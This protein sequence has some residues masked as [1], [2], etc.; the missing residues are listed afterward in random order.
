MGWGGSARQAFVSSVSPRIRVSG[1]LAIAG[2]W[3]SGRTSD[4]VLRLLSCIPGRGSECV[5]TY[6]SESMALGVVR[7]RWETP[8]TVA[9]PARIARCGPV[10][11]VSDAAVYGTEELGQS[12]ERA[13]CRPASLAPPELLAAAVRIWGKRCLERIEG[14][15]AFVAWDA[16]TRTL[17]AARDPFGTRTLFF[18]AID[19]SVFVSSTPH[20]LVEL[21]GVVPPFDPGGLLRSLVMQPGGSRATAWE[22]VRELPPGHLLE[23]SLEENPT[24]QLDG[25]AL[26]PRIRRFWFPAA[27]PGMGALASDAAPGALAHRLQRAVADRIPEVGAALAMSGGYD[28]TALAGAYFGGK[29]PPPSPLHI[30]SFR[31]HRDDPANEDEYVNA[32]ARAFGLPIHWVETDYLGLL[33][34]SPQ[35]IERRLFPEGHIHESQNRALARAARERG[36]RVL[37]NGN[38]GDNMIFGP[39]QVMGDLLRQGRWFAL[40]RFFRSRGYGRWGTFRDFA[41]RPAVPLPFLDAVERLRGRPINSRPFEQPLPPWITPPDELLGEMRRLDR[42]AYAEAVLANHGRVERRLRA[43]SASDPMFARVCASLFD[44]ARDEGVELRFPFYDGRIV[45][46]ALARPIEEM[47]RPGELKPLL[48]DSM[49]ERLPDQVIAPRLEGKWKTG[50][51]VEYSRKR[52]RTE[53]GGRLSAL[54]QPWILEELGL[55]SPRTYQSRLTANLAGDH[56]WEVHLITTLAVEEWLQRQVGRQAGG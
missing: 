53:I 33:D 25:H 13:G 2:S 35:Q 22:G 18:R 16:S 3:L 14:D 29:A 27:D 42:T 44:L 28:S 37:L 11:L 15:Y 40:R 39:I 24:A 50:M 6:H 4:G 20:P 48:R 45:S 19:G 31:Y 41:L 52:F 17:L 34:R 55:V 7:D 32:V 36:V 49:K 5:D 12:L 8:D 10:F 38:G 46:F 56:S 54:D 26:R 30:L 43:W 47:T 21:D 1:V 9:G 51:I 23:V